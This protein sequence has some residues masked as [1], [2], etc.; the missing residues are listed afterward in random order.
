MAEP[1]TTTA[2][3]QKKR[4]LAPFNSSSNNASEPAELYDTQSL[5]AHA[6]S[7]PTSSSPY[8]ALSDAPSPASSE[9]TRHTTP[10]RFLPPHLHEE[11]QLSRE[12]SGGSQQQATEG[13]S[14]SNA[15]AEITIDS[16]SSAEMSG[17]ENGG[18]SGNT[19]QQRVVSPGRILGARSAS[20]A[21][22]TAADMEGSTGDVSMT[23][24]EM[25]NGASDQDEEMRE[26]AP[27]DEVMDTQETAV[28]S[29][30]NLGQSNTSGQSS[31]TSFQSDA[32]PP[33]SAQDSS[34]KI[35]PTLNY[36]THDIDQQEA[37]VMH[38]MNKELEPGQK[39]IVI[40]KKWLARVLSRSTEGLKSNQ[41]SK[42]AREGPLGPVDN[43]DIVPE[44]GFVEPILHDVNGYPFIPLVP[45][46]SLGQD[47]EVFT[48]EAWGVVMAHYGIEKGQKQIDRYALDSAGENA[49]MRNVIY[50]TYP[51][52]FTI[53][54]VPQPKQD[55]EEER[56]TSSKSNAQQHWLQAEQRKRGQMS[57][58]DAVKLVSSRHE[59][60]QKFLARA[61]DAAGIP[62]NS[63]VRIFKALDP[64]NAN[65]VAQPDGAAVAADNAD[66]SAL[67]S[68]KLVVSLE[69]FS[70]MELGKD[71]DPIEVL[72]QTDNSN[73]NGSSNMELYILTE[74]ATLLLEQQIGGPAG[75]DYNSDKKSGFN[76]FKLAG[77]KKTNSSQPAS[78]VNSR[79][80]SPAPGA[81]IMTRGRTRRDG[82]TKGTVG[83]NNLGNTCYM[84]SALQCI[85]SCEELAIYFL[86]NKYKADINSNNPLGHGGAMAKQYANLLTNIYADNAGSTVNP[87]SF[88]RTLGNFAPM[89]SGWGQQD[90]QEFLS[91][92]VDALHEDLNRILKK[93]YNENP[94][95]TDET[96]KDPQK[97][98]ELGET[99]RNNHRAR[100]DSV[101]MDL[102]NGFYKNTMECP[103]CDKISITFDPFSLLTVQLPNEGSFQHTVTFVPLRS[104][105][106]NHAIDCDKGWTI[107]MLLENIASKHPGVDVDRL[108]MAEV[109]NHKI[110]KI[111]E[112]SITLGE[113][114][115]IANDHL[116]V[117]ELEHTPS[118]PAVLSKR[119]ITYGSK[120]L[121]DKI[122][123]M[124]DP[125]ADCFA[126]PVFSR[127]KNRTGSGW[128]IILHPMY[129]T[130]TREEA[131]DSEV[132]L[133]KVLIAASRMTSRP[134]LTE[135]SEDVGDESAPEDAMDTSEKGAAVNGPT[136]PEAQVNDTSSS[137]DGYVNVS[138]ANGNPSQINGIPQAPKIDE[139]E[140]PQRFMDSQYYIAPALRSHLFTVNFAPS[141]DGNLHC[142]GM[143]SIKD[144][145]VRNMFDRVKKPSRRNSMQSTSSE[146][147]S[148]STGS[149]AGENGQDDDNGDID[150]EGDEPDMVIG[151]E[152]AQAAGDDE[153]SDLFDDPLQMSRK[154]RRNKN[155]G[156][157]RTGKRRGKQ[158]TYGKRDRQMQQ[159]GL[160]GKWR[161]SDGGKPDDEE[162]PYY[163]K[164][165]EA[166][167]LD[168]LPE[169]LDSLF[170]GKPQDEEDLRGHFVSSHDSKGIPFVNDP[171]V[172][173]KKRSRELRKKHGMTLDE[174]FRETGKREVLSED[175]AWYCNRCKELRRATKTLEI[176]TLPDVLVVHLKRFGGNR[177]FR[178][179]IDTLVDYPIEGL[180]MTERV[181]LKE[182][183]KEYVYDLFA[184]DNHFGGLGGGHYTAYAKNFY[185]GFWYD[186]NGK[187]NKIED[188]ALNTQSC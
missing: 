15:L 38:K 101:A 149:G 95:S 125:K 119:V 6:R 177:S 22:R 5:S 45:G 50:E 117:F 154:G 178:D 180:D 41:Y 87:Q 115:I 136:A 26:S 79:G 66:S 13:S 142:T 157:K 170:N 27:V 121:D 147:S 2:S 94:D 10:P 97:I 171:E 176:W 185:D 120:S 18:A 80:T 1:T 84:N 75:G 39:G 173:E 65:M 23:G 8:T 3:S 126:V 88:K 56:P 33:Y 168:W 182:E 21:K 92:L 20:P 130:L 70:K 164:L 62:R 67:P 105:P 85:R 51:P 179:K 25:Q 36:S 53:R 42:E 174:C 35:D 78:T 106:V 150:F 82:R 113:A 109:Y 156:R 12:L 37:A 128:D 11:V 175:N 9:T 167:V 140:V 49:T 91:F 166:I 187:S 153:D 34:M 162:N 184:V 71:L 137:E 58:D 127:Q 116:F 148:T 138:L 112:N 4:R 133:K 183:G 98:I 100:N 63:K 110:Y 89:F 57:P 48:Q 14:P 134:I 107:K 104:T 155:K 151:G 102:F 135:M 111:F 159:N 141:A 122:P 114:G 93:P 54:K 163:I 181:G 24:R 68:S 74:P 46:L 86:S 77:L 186:Y 145:S 146:E 19:D 129:I 31:A 43:S 161:P 108:W 158:L 103:K 40:S 47:F 59:K 124:D 44:N 52:V 16:G 7:S 32:P 99:Y 139:R 188:P 28:S 64:S 30:S 123:E 29:L 55:D 160:G 144:H 96:V 83:L 169:A 69:D 132:I 76:K 90:S 165:G 60:F 17:S 172:E 72:D 152:T 131:Q 81:G 61:K 73:Y 143:S 118:N